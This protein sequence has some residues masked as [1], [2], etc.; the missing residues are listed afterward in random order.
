MLIEFKF[1]NFRSFRDETCLSMR[2]VSP[3]KRG[4]GLLPCEPGNLLPAVAISGKNGEGKTNVIRA[5]AFAVQFI[6]NAQRT[7]HE[8][9]SIPV[10]LFL[11][12]DISQS[13]PA[14]FE[15]TYILDGFKY[16]YGFATT[17]EKIE[18]EYL[19]QFPKGRKALVFC[20]E[21]QEF[22][23][24]RS[25]DRKKQRMICE[26]VAPNQLYFALA[27]TLNEKVCASAMC[28]FRSYLVFSW[29]YND[30]SKCLMKFPNMLQTIKEDILAADIEIQ[31]ITFKIS[32]DKLS[33]SAVHRGSNRNGEEQLYDLPL[34][35][36]SEGV[37]RF[38][39]LVSAVEHTLGCGGVFLVD[40]LEEH[41][42]PLLARFMLSK[43]QSLDS[44][45]N[46]AQIIFTTHST[47]LLN[48]GLLQK[49]QIYVAS[50][51]KRDNSSTLTLITSEVK[52]TGGIHHVD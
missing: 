41:L 1:S 8:S 50:K 52:A 30:P 31:D 49:G 21:G 32:N 33:V 34:S 11:L 19:H 40:G 39:A 51:G 24:R 44:N 43:F 28:W 2:S 38:I 13:A 7:Q 14:S 35:L 20:R 45:P 17:K 25:A 16:I 42:H 9:A 18:K 47:E 26:V 36:E 12:D 48:S 22:T 5:F 15:F 29:D 27:C 37:K 3:A 46:H 4:E 23:F 6:C 10:E